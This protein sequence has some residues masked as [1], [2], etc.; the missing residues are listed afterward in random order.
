[1]T[2]GVPIWTPETAAEAVKKHGSIRAAARALECGETSLRKYYNRAIEMGIAEPTK[3]NN[4]DL[5]P[6]KAAEA[7]KTHGSIRSAASATGYSETTLRKW[8][9]MAVKTGIAPRLIQGQISRHQIKEF[10]KLKEENPPVVEGRVEAL[11]AKEFSVP[12]KGVRRY[13]FTCAQNNTPLFEPF[14]DNLLV[15]AEHYKASIHISRFL[16]VK[17]GLGARGDKAD[18]VKKSKGSGA[19]DIWFDPRIGQ[20]LSD[21]RCEIAP[22]LVWCG[23]MNILPTAVNPLSG[24]EIYT[25]RKSG[26]FP[27]AKVAMESVPSAKHDAVKFNYTTGT[28]TQRNYIERKAG[29]KA[30]FHHAYGAMLVEVDTNGSW[31]CR[32]IQGDDKGTLYDLDIKVENEELT[33][34]NPVEAITWGDIHAIRFD[35][36]VEELGW[37]NNDSMV[38]VL[39]PKNQFLHD[40]LDFRGRNHHET[41]DPFKRLL[42]F[43]EREEDVREEVE[44]TMNKVNEL[45]NYVRNANEEGVTV[46]VDSNHDRALERWLRESDWRHDPINMEFFME[47]ALAKIRAIKDRDSSFH[48][49]RFWASQLGLGDREDIIFLDEDESY[50]ICP[51]PDGHGGI[52]C[53]MHGH[54]GPNGRRGNIRAFSKM[55]RRANIGH[56]HTAG[57]V[58]GIYQAG[59][60]SELDLGYNVGPGSW[61]QSHVITYA[62]GKRAIITM[63]ASKWRG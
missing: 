52:E 10:F 34:G 3:G 48:M 38:N 28:V 9:N 6:E 22:G 40:V 61:S 4:S 39:R 1:M 17:Q 21:E 54:L 23:E 35:S 18:I 24:M 32:Q 15:L 30:D 25:G 56:S 53:G 29:L 8:Y 13:I 27:H 57:I 31:W 44:L 51:D 16:Y 58:D 19:N 47:S 63:W 43:V 7:V 14:W 5:S 12:K 62:N 20:Y 33:T 49:I 59:T 26:I 37:V 36:I 2:F 11:R 60:S 46:V 41:K 42:R 45:A 50:V 55:G